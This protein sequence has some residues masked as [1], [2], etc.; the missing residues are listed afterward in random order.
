MK[1]VRLE[2]DLTGD[3]A[4]R[5][6]AIEE[7]KEKTRAEARAMGLSAE[8]LA[9]LEKEMNRTLESLR[10]RGAQAVSIDTIVGVIDDCVEGLEALEKS[11]VTLGHGAF[12][13]GEGAH[14]FALGGIRGDV[15]TATRLLQ[16]AARR[17]EHIRDCEHCKAKAAKKNESAAQEATA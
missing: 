16:V 11:L 9:E 14:V 10:E 12:A 7:A 3:N 4:E 13:E 1:T 2:V 17:L 6:A 8:Q 5:A 15:E